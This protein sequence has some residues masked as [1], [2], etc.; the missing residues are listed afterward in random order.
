MSFFDDNSHFIYANE[1]ERDEYSSLKIRSYE[2]Y[3]YSDFIPAA[4]VEIKAETKKAFLLTVNFEGN[5]KIGW[6]PKK[7]I[8]IDGANL[9]IKAWLYERK[10]NNKTEYTNQPPSKKDLLEIKIKELVFSLNKLKI[11]KNNYPFWDEFKKSNYSFFS[12]F[13]IY[14]KNEE[15]DSFFSQVEQG[16]NNVKG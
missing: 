11:N 12:D 13:L 15:M 16:G 9:K 1:G 4:L 14:E 3:R 6:Y 2:G 7:Y 8:I 10:K 5:E